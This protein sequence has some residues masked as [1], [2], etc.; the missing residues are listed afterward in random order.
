MATVYCTT[1][2]FHERPES[3]EVDG[4]NGYVKLVGTSS[5]PDG[6][7]FDPTLEYKPPTHPI[8]EEK[9]APGASRDPMAVSRTGHARLMLDMY[10]AITGGEVIG[11]PSAESAA[12]TTGIFNAAYESIV[13][14][15][16]VYL[17]NINSTWDLRPD[18]IINRVQSLF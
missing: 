14:G 12:D 5:T 16:E 3:I 7:V 11:L 1:A 2:S 9:S 15:R 17:S 6:W 8:P 18:S 13:S 4:K 10:N